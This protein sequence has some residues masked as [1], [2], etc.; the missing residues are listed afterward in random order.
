MVVRSRDRSRDSGCPARQHPG[1]SPRSTALACHPGKPCV[2]SSPPSVARRYGWKNGDNQ[3]GNPG[4][5]H[6]HD[7]R[8]ESVAQGGLR[9][10]IVAAR[11]SGI[12][13]GCRVDR[14]SAAASLAFER[15]AAPV[16]LDVH[17]KDG[18]VMD[19]AIDDSDRHGLVAEHGAM[20]Q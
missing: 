6:R 18:G 4:S 2:P 7:C 9:I 15:G 19:E 13:H 14:R 12:D 8:G 10:C 3:D 17:F 5:Q 16:A 20:L 1:Q 11:R